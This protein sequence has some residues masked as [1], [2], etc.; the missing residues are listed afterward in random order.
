MDLGSDFDG[1]EILDGDKSWEAASDADTVVDDDEEAFAPLVR[2]LS[3]G[4]FPSVTLVDLAH[5]TQSV[6]RFV[7]LLVVR[8]AGSVVILN[9]TNY[10]FYLY[11]LWAVHLELRS[12][13]LVT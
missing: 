6:V 12:I 8:G 13:S 11:R 7:R 4:I 10:Q 2:S 5:R 9:L 1:V 3:D